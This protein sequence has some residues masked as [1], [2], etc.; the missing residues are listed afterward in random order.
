MPKLST[1]TDL[2]R[3]K[4]FL[5]GLTLPIE[6]SAGPW[7]EPR[8]LTANAYLWKVCYQPLVE[9][10]EFSSEEWHSHYCGEYFG[11]KPVEMPSGKLEYKPIRTTTKNE[12][13]ERDVLKGEPFNQFLC[14]VEQD[15]AKRG[16]FIEQGRVV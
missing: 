8:K 4:T 14:F 6:V 3:W 12:K 10:T 16:I 5:D 9:Q 2:T 13:G 1:P 7:K 11:W 15:V